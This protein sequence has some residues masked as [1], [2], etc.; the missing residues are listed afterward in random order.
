[1]DIEVHS[2]TRTKRAIKAKSRKTAKKV[3]TSHTVGWGDYNVN[4]LVPVKVG[5]QD[6]SSSQ[7]AGRSFSICHDKDRHYSSAHVRLE[8]A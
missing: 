3:K 5:A 8:E 1:M 6:V 4:F 2:T 7:A